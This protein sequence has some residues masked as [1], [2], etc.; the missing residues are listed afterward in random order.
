MQLI[1]SFFYQII[2][3]RNV[4][5]FLRNL[6]KLF[7]PWLTKVRLHPSGSLNITTTQDKK[8]KL[9][10]NQTDFVAFC[11]FWDGLYNYEYLDIF[12]KVMSKCTG[13]IDV[14][15]NAGL[16]SLIARAAN[17]NIKVIAVDPS[18]AT[19]YYVPKNLK[20][21]KFDERITFHNVA[22]SDSEE[23]M[24]FYEVKNPKYP[25]LEYNL[26]G[27]SSLYEKPKAYLERKVKVT[28]IDLLVEDNTSID[29]IDFVKIDAEGAEPQIIKGMQETI[30]QHKPIIVC[31]ILF[32]LIEAELEVVFSGHGFDFY[33]HTEH[34]LTP[35]SSIIRST[36]NGV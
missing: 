25:Y 20:A 26:G 1:K 31:E 7:Y 3:Q 33:Y 34:G 19:S 15:A 32:N 13:F 8:I 27:A 14:G 22:L 35:T 29:S 16:F 24:T 11:I 36:D 4:N 6:N 17:N 2:Y 21:N 5:Y 18:F 12:E 28:T 23:E 9:F 10:T 30:R